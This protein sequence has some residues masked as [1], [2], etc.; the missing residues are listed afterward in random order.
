MVAMLLVRLVAQV[1]LA[2]VVV[3]V[4]LVAVVQTAAQE[5]F[6]FSTRMELI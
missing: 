1:V 5:F 2:V 4:E 3:Q 6:I